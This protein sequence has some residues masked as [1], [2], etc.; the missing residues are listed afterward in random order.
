VHSL[1][2]AFQPGKPVLAALLL[3][4]KTT[5]FAVIAG[6][7]LLLMT[8]GMVFRRFSKDT[9]DYFRAGGKATW[10]LIGGSV[11][12]Q[13]FSA[14]MF[15]GAAGAAF[16]AGWSLPLMHVSNVLA[17]LT[18]AAFSGPWFRQLRCVTAA[19]LV[20]LRFGAGMEQFF[21]Y[22]GLLMGPVFGGVQLYGLAIFTSILLGVNINATIVVLGCVVL[23]YA[24]ISGAWAVMAADCIKALVLVPITVLLAVVCLGKIGGIGGLFAAIDHAGLT[25]AYA[26]VKTPAVLATLSGIDPGRFTWAFYLAWFANIVLMGNS[27]T[28]GG[29]YLGAKDGREAR[30]AAL[31]A[32]GL[33]LLGLLIWF[34]PPMTARL[35]IAGEVMSMPLANPAEGA[36]AAIAVHL[37]PAGLVGLVLVGMCAATMSALDVSLNALAGNITQNIYPAACRALRIAPWEGRA[38]L[39]FAKLVTV[40]CAFSVVGVSLAMARFGRGGVFSILIDV[41]A[42]IAA[43]ISVPLVLGLVLR[44]VPVAAPFASIGTGFAVSLSIFLAPRLFGAHPWLFQSQVGAVIGVSL[45]TFLVVRALCPPD[46]TALAREQEFFSRRDRPVDFAAEIGEGND[47]RQ[48]RIIGAFGAALGLAVLLLLIPA[49]SAGH[50]GQIL[51]VA[52]S[53]FA[54]GSLMLWLGRNADRPGDRA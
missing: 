54:L 48:L 29:R 3:Q 32:A 5:I 28:N 16:Q 22:L 24:G 9:S 45:V 15:T 43:P 19:D 26:P 39:V 14:W 35:L 42:T 10:W 13:G 53:T 8:V 51:A 21:A 46:D 30:R 1:I 44:R 40:F 20:R 47:H 25:A 23:F 52:L 36:Y 11:F 33:F 38:R 50:A 27:F 31:L 49:S 4:D 18:I 17:F 41:M 7:F 2:L 6:Y 37:L 12:M 34:I